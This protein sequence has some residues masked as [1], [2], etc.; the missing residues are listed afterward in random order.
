MVRAAIVA[1][2]SRPG[3]GEAL[4]ELADGLAARGW[5]VTADAALTRNLDRPLDAPVEPL[6]WER[7]EAD[8]V[9]TL[10]GDGTLLYAA[11]RLAARPI[12]IF[13]VNLGGLGF[14]TAASPEYL[15]PPLEAALEGRAPIESRM[16]LSAEVVRDGKARSRRHALNDAV[17]H[18]GGAL[19]TLELKLRI[20]GEELG[21]YLADGLILSTPTGASGYNLSAAGPLAVPDLDIVLLTPICAHTLAIRPIVTSGDQ[22]IEVQ[23]EQGGEGMLLILD[24]QL[25]EP[26]ARGDV[27]RV[28]RGDHRVR[29]AGLDTGAYFER[30]R[31]KLM[32]GG[33]AE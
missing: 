26:L 11:R 29:L 7:L 23:V 14:L 10:G 2:P 16:T 21:A 8:L 1:N 19:R 3:V 33:R 31:E 24:G 17:I 30:L 12:P 20:G 32:W 15:W 22:P 13:G 9:I 4:R 27:V 25:E 28:Q 18:K 5:E 6:D